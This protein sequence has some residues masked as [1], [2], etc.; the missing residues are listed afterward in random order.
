[1]LIQTNRTFRFCDN[2]KRFVRHKEMVSAT[3]LSSNFRE[4]ILGLRHESKFSKEEE[5]WFKEGT[6]NHEEIQKDFNEMDTKDKYH[7]FRE[8]LITKRM[9]V[10]FKEL[11]VVS[12]THALYGKIDLIKIHFDKNNNINIWIDE[13][14]RGWNKRHFY[15]LMAYLLMLSDVNARVVYGE[16]YKRVT[17]NKGR[18]KRPVGYLYPNPKDI[19]K[20]NIK[21]RFYY[22]GDDSINK[23]YQDLIIN[24]EVAPYFYGWFEAM[25][26]RLH[27]YQEIMRAGA[28]E[29]AMFRHDERKNCCK[30][31]PDFCPKCKYNPK[32]VQ[33]HFGK[34]K[35]IVKSRG[36][37]I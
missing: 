14:K 5:I 15:Q 4:F 28:V 3:R 25:I 11:N 18:M 29:L 30:H 23:D 12:P 24:G 16:Q 8:I 13:I 7:N 19:N 21:G 22:Y 10:A 20:I 37:R 34:R 17:E 36:K 33:Y 6:R 1:M 27:Q 26:N 2:P 35:P 9:P 31:F 32:L